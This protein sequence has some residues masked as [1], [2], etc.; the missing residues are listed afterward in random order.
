M[1]RQNPS[2]S[3]RGIGASATRAISTLRD[4]CESAPETAWVLAL[5]V[6]WALLAGLSA[7]LCGGGFL[8][9]ESYSFLPHYLSDRPLLELIYDNRITDW[10][11]YQAREL[12]FLFAWLDCQF[13]AWSVAHGR[14]HFFSI[15]HYALL[16][17]GGLALWRIAAGHL[18][19]SRCASAALVLLLWSSPS[20]ML[21][22]SFYRCA[23]VALL[24]MTLLAI[25]AWFRAR[26]LPAG[27]RASAAVAGFGML[28]FLLPMCDKL[29]LLFLLGM[30]CFL[31]R[32]ALASRTTRDWHLLL[33]AIIA[34]ALAWSYQ[35][36]MGPAMTRHFL[37]YEV[38][39][40][41]TAV[42]FADLASSPRL[43]LTV[44]GGAPVFTLDSFRFPL[45]DLPAGLALL[46]LAGMT[47]ILA[48]GGEARRPLWL[49]RGWLFPALPVF[50]AT[51]FAAMLAIFPQMFSNEH[52]RFYYPLPAAGLW[53]P[54]IA[55]ALAE[56]LRRWPNRR[57]WIELGLAG[58][59]IGNV[60]ALQEH[61][62]F[63]RRGKYEP[64]V[65]N[66]ARV[67]NA[68]RP[69]RSAAL[70]SAHAAELLQKAPYFRDAVPPS[71]DQ[72]RIFLALYP[73]VPAAPEN[74]GPQENP[75]H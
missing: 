49:A 28:G 24:A 11:T 16:L 44:L 75:I 2:A 57:P 58:V 68:L 43:L 63:L 71:L 31:A 5:V 72:D 1:T 14:P 7:G 73:R 41:Y 67:R 52:R 74:S 69:P 15:S 13:I 70:T 56:V 48:T 61:R 29:G 51:T 23:K 19:L 45:G 4:G 36:F 17:A 46:A 9:P 8:H 53:F 35:R 27:W 60:V 39:R 21:Y 22:T 25:W 3:W 34:L 26:G 54:A 42:P 59:L 50:I 33:A 40:G 30:T 55:V 12:G 65:E 62:F 64:F 47:A 38:N 20:A 32:N 10:G 18:G 66:A 37:H 6:G